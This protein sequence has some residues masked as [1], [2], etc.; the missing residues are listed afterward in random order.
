VRRPQSVRRT[1][2]IDIDWPDGTANT[3]RLRGHC[4]DT[5][6][7]ENLTLRELGRDWVEASATETRDFSL[8]SSSRQPGGIKELEGSRAGNRLRSL[9]RQTYP[10]QEAQLDGHFLLLDDLAGASLVSSWGWLAWTRAFEAF[11]ANAK[12]KQIGGN[13]GDMRGVCIGL[14]QGSHALDEDGY[15]RIEQQNSERVTELANGA[16]P[17]GWH[18]PPDQLGPSTRRA[19]WLDV[20]REGRALHASGGFQDSAIETDG[21]RLAIHEYRFTCEIDEPSGMI[22]AIQAVPH[23]LPHGNCP[24]AVLGVNRIV[25]RPIAALRMHVPVLFARE[26]G[27]TH[28]NDV[29]RALVCVPALARH[30]PGE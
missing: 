17:L 5:V 3:M 18:N 6:T 19:R 12:A 7:G 23:V 21:G 2:S 4:R 13:D 16:D 9:L 27:C 8:V 11:T 20:W 29:M 15:P 24:A 14:A 30:L 28:L 22:S 10:D 1:T 26:A 25:G